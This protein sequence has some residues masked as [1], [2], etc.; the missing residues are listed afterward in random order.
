MRITIILLV[1]ALLTVGCADSH[2]LIRNNTNSVSKLTPNDSF[3]IAVSRDGVYGAKIYQGSGLSSSQVLHS[4]L[5]KH[6]RNVQSGQ[7][8]LPFEESLKYARDNNYKY[9]VYPTI[10]EWEDRATEWSGIPDRVELKIEFI[11]TATGRIVESGIVKGKSGLGTFG[12]D[13]PQD[14][15]PIPINEFV[16][17]LF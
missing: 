2:Q 7:S 8:F 1:T 17:I 6:A 4:A 9:L 13:H 12:G 14:L 15:L 16:S 5:S 3:Y 10:L 11:Q